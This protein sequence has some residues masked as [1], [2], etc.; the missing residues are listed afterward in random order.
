[1]FSTAAFDLIEFSKSILPSGLN[2]ENHQNKL[3]FHYNVMKKID[4][5]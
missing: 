1:M 4:K 3:I 5:I 2:P